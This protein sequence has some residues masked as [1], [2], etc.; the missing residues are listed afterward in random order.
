MTPHRILLLSSTA[1]VLTASRLFTAEPLLHPL[2]SDHM[3]FP[4]D[5]TTPVWGWTKAGQEVEV[6]F[7]GQTAKAKAGED[8]RWEVKLNPIPASAEPQ[9]LTASTAGASQTI[10][11]VLVGDV[12]IC[13]GQSNM[14]WPVAASNNAD[15]EIAAANHPKLRLFTVPKKTTYI[16]VS[17][18]EAAW[19]TTT[20]ETIKNFSAVGYYFGRELLQT[21]NVP[22]GLINTSWGG[23]IAEAWVSREGLASLKDFAPALEATKPFAEGKADP[24]E[25]FFAALDAWVA[26]RDPAGL[27]GDELHAADFDDTAWPVR[28]LP[29]SWNKDAIPDYHGVMWVR[30][31]FEVSEARAAQGGRLALGPVDAYTSVWLNGQP[32]SAP[33]AYKTNLTL[34]VPAGLLKAGENVLAIRLAGADVTGFK[35][36]PE[37]FVLAGP[38]DSN[39]ASLPL[40]GEWRWRSGKGKGEALAFPTRYSSGPNFVTVLS[41][42]MIEPLVPFAVKGAIWYQGESNASRAAQYRKLLPALITDWRKR[43]GTGDFPFFIVQLANFMARDEKPVDSQWAEL[44]E[45]QLFTAR[46]VPQSGLASAIDIGEADDIHPRNKQDVG[47]RLALEARRVAYG[48]NIESRGPAFKALQIEVGK[49]RVSFDHAEGLNVKGGGEPKGFAIAAKDGPYVWAKAELQGNEIV[50]SSP[51]VPQPARVRYAWGNNPETN[52]YNAADLP[53]EPFRTDGPDAK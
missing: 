13:S 41:N 14:E 37:E 1:L 22:I 27:F 30:R 26:E 18:P 15:Q 24:E 50:L 29:E 48:E 46:T 53:A 11:G 10:S 9:T 5:K 33:R 32:L 2:F 23:T 4:R 16:P 6:S 42:G 51:E 38:K 40:K 20:P 35:A 12:W 3:V 52:L 43:F 34:D 8:G 39:V 19:T 31:T 36:K 7:A 21:Q 28:V 49:V 44:R 45:A 17:R 25:A 47:K